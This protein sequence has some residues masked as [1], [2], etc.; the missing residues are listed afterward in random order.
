MTPQPSSSWGLSTGCRSSSIGPDT[1]KP[2]I[3]NNDTFILGIAGAPFS[4]YIKLAESIANRIGENKVK[5]INMKNF[6]K[7]KRDPKNATEEWDKWDHNWE[8]ESA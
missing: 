2:K 8:E 3:E 7:N 5:I 4:G 6:L 1:S